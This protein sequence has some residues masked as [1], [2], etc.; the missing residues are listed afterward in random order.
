MD[1]SPTPPDP[2]ELPHPPPETCCQPS[3]SPPGTPAQ[4]PDPE[5]DPASEDK[6]TRT[7][8]VARLPKEMRDQLNQMILD[9]VPFGKI[10]S[11][12]GE[13]ASHLNED[14]I[15]NW[16]KGGY[17]DWLLDLERKQ[18]LSA[19]REAALD[20]VKEKAGA[21]VQDAGR[22]IAAAQL[23]ELLLSFDP[24]SFHSALA[25]KP[26]LYLKLIGALSRLSEGEAAC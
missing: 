10:I 22:T 19:T 25:D 6:R 26:E 15:T 21:T 20:L 2:P 1:P 17:Q 11:N 14:N 4:A 5:P 13:S 24:T 9:G 12:L 18:A 7:G 16:K 3:V 8:K 23:Y